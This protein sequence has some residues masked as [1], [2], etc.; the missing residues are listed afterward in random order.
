MPARIYTVRRRSRRSRIA[1]TMFEP[2]ASQPAPF[3]SGK[4][5][6]EALD[7]LVHESAASEH[8]LA[9]R[10]E[11]L[12]RAGRAGIGGDDLVPRDAGCPGGPR[13]AGR[14]R[15]PRRPL[16]AAWALDG[17][18]GC[19]LGLRDGVGLELRCAHAIAGKRCH[20]VARPAE[21]DDERKRRGDVCEAW[22]LQLHVSPLPRRPSRKSHRPVRPGALRPPSRPDAVGDAPEEGKGAVRQRS[23]APDAAAFRLGTRATEYCS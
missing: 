8:A 10:A 5:P 14:A 16:P 13:G 2:S 12:R 19:E 1:V 11:R 7:A 15:R 21:R 18:A 20:G 17:E 3:G 23:A 4:A 22:S 6:E 9:G